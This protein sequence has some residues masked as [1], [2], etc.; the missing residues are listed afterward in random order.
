VHERLLLDERDSLFLV[1]LGIVGFG[2]V[3]TGLIY[4]TERKHTATP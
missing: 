3:L 2:F 4:L 1:L